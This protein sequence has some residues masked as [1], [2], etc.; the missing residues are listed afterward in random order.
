MGHSQDRRLEFEKVL[1]E[2][3]ILIVRSLR[4]IEDDLTGRGVQFEL[5]EKEKELAR[6][7]FEPK[8]F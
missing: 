2:Y 7:I 1:R 5:G 3:R 8:Q 4:C 6:L